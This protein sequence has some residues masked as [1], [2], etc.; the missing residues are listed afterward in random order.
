[1]SAAQAH[2]Q[3]VAACHHMMCKKPSHS[4][5]SF[6]ELLT[7]PRPQ[8]TTQFITGSFPDLYLYSYMVLASPT[9]HAPVVS[10]AILFV[11]Q[12]E[13]GYPED[14]LIVTHKIL[15]H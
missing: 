2:L 7:P 11:G 9:C 3:E 1:M 10:P 13:E 15:L 8:I 14:N 6:W 4:F 12:G 5:S